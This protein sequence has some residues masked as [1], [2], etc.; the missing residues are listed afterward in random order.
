[1]GLQDLV[2]ESHMLDVVVK[3]NFV[4]PAG[5]YSESMGRGIATELEEHLV[6]AISKRDLIVLKV[7][8]LE[9]VVQ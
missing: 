6:E 4:A 8:E 5:H 1:M 7:E 2:V 9:I 3:I